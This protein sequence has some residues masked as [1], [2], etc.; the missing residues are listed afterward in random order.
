MERSE[1]QTRAKPILLT[2]LRLDES[3]L[4]P[5]LNVVEDTQADSLDVMEVFLGLEEEF[6]IEFPP[7]AVDRIRTLDQAVDVIYELV[8]AP[9]EA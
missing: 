9:A 4:R 2:A 7:E 3:T 8:N 1:I 5:D 6:D